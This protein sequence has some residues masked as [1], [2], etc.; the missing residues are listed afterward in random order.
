[1]GF[2]EHAIGLSATSTGDIGT[3]AWGPQTLAGVLRE[4]VDTGSLNHTWG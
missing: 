2:G 1:M 3:R 4:S